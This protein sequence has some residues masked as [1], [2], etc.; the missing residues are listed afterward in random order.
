VS[1]GLSP[2]KKKQRRSSSP[3]GKH[4]PTFRPDKSIPEE[5]RDTS[6]IGNSTPKPIYLPPTFYDLTITDYKTR[7]TPSLPP[8]E[9]T[10]SSQLQLMLYHR[11]LTG[12]LSPETFDFDALWA[13]QGINPYKSFSR[14]FIEDIGWPIEDHSEFHM[15]LCS[16]VAVWIS[17]VHLVRS[18]GEPLRGVS[19]ELQ[20]IYRKAGGFKKN[21]SYN[22][23]KKPEFENKSSENSLEALARQ[24]ELDMARA[25]EESL[26]QLNQD[27]RNY[28][29]QNTHAL[30]SRDLL[31]DQAVDFN[32]P[33]LD[34]AKL[35]GAVQDSSLACGSDIPDS[36]MRPN[37][38]K[39]CEES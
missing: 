9:D 21:A 3:S 11:L 39:D 34:N 35:N 13:K 16:M 1:S 23:Q 31:L 8:E 29:H 17:T 32:N 33:A 30:Q 15:D 5:I 20:I 36:K 28:D 27:T 24:E 25:I 6:V 12:L 10:A 4:I 22:P 26:H 7:R 14:S 19:P 38:T 2:A 18:C 37:V